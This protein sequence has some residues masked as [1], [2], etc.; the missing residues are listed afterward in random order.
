MSYLF[1]TKKF[2]AL[3][4]WVNVFVFHRKAIKLNLCS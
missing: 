4:A 1:Y 2:V 3:S